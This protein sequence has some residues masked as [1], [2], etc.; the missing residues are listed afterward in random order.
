MSLMKICINKTNNEMVFRKKKKNITMPLLTYFI[1]NL[2]A[3]IHYIDRSACRHNIRIRMLIRGNSG[4]ST[5]T[6]I[7][8]RIK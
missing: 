7:H 6:H 4:S 1:Y 8:I 2:I 5:K 3:D